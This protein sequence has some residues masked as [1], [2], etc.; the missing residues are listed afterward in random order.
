MK[1]F[2]IDLVVTFNT[3]NGTMVC[4]IPNFSI[5]AMDLDHAEMILGGFYPLHSGCIECV[6][7]GI[8]CEETQQYHSF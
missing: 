4:Q 6:H 7:G 2:L 1:R 5:E 3:K 8:I